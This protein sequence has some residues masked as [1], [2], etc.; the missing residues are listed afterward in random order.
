MELKSYQKDVIKN[1]RRYL[2]LMNAS[3]DYAKAYRDLMNEQGVIIG[4]G[5]VP[6]YKDTVA[7]TPHVCFKVPTG[8]G[9]TFLAVNSVRP[10][11]EAMP[12]SQ[13]KVVVWLV[14]SDA[15]LEQTYRNLSDK[16]SPYR[17]KLDVDFSGSVEVI[18]KQAALEGQCFNVTT[19]NES[20]I[21][22]VMSYDSFRA[23]N[24]EGRKVYQE[25]GALAQFAKIYK[26]KDITIADCDETALAQV[27]N[28]LNPLVVVDE[29]HH[30]TSNLSVDV[31]KNLNPCFILD[32]TATPKQNSNIIAYVD[33]LKLK[34]ESMV[35][36]P[37][38][39]YNRRTQ[40]DAI[41]DAVSLRNNLEAAAETERK[42]AGRYLRPIVL[43]Q[44]QPRTDTDSTTFE[45]IKDILINADIPAEQIA[46]KTS[47]I[48]ELKNVDL[49]S[50]DCPI[51]YIIT[52][53]ALKEGWDC[54]FAYILA[55]IANRS[56]IVD[57]EQILG[58]VLRQP[59]AKNFTSKFLNMSYVL[60][61]SDDFRATTENVIAG[62][63]SAGFSKRDMRL[64]KDA[65]AEVPAAHIQPVP[66]Q[67]LEINENKLL[68]NELDI[69]PNVLKAELA[70]IKES[71]SALVLTEE[72]QQAEAAA[73][74]YNA[75]VEEQSA[76]G[77]SSTSMELRD[78]MNLFY[79]NSEFADT[80]KNIKVPQ[81]FIKTD[82]VLFADDPY[83]LLD[84]ERLNDGFT[85]R[86]KS[87]EIDFSAT[88][89]EI[90]RID[91]EKSN[92]TPKSVNLSEWDTKAFKQYFN[93][94]TPAARTDACK[95][96]IEQQL[97]KIK[98]IDTEDLSMYVGRVVDLMNSDMLSDLEANV[99]RYA[100]K[101]KK[102]IEALLEEYAMKR[103]R[104]LIDKGKIVCR[105]SY[106]FEEPITPISSIETLS[107][108]LYTA[109]DKN[110]NGFE[111][112]AINKIASLDNVL[113]WH[114][115]TA[116]KG[117]CINGFTN[118]YPDFLVMTRSG[119]LVAVETKGDYLDTP[120][121]R[122]KLE[123]GRTWASKAGDD[124]AYYMVFQ[125]KKLNIDGAYHLDKFIDIIKEL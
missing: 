70:A 74:E 19:V 106:V 114:R 21:I 66:I 85:L 99:L 112:T 73:E 67:Q 119:R 15:I 71:P 97:D 40:N 60:T 36:L 30:A 110:M 53:N 81:F 14:P 42:T 122:Q 57:V 91:V 88:D 26:N 59:N 18:T 118:H 5:G 45:K 62:L 96:K 22:L 79:I 120:E 10:I 116:G 84:K 82:A 113:W 121:T 83:I 102:K 16:N 108:S 8:G 86:D 61:C 69:D 68:S 25:N 13:P 77:Y 4:A 27:L 37:V 95:R 2:E 109:E 43:F 28:C 1:L 100:D 98:C 87:T 75:A 29:S 105:P 39:V 41:R 3:G 104:G 55:T 93:S 89:G 90:V 6:D 38:I 80:V 124:F 7:H 64:G 101:I 123:L 50:E 33:A 35:K 103:F 17:R 12:L 125:H 56:S 65:S 49:M 44:A 92:T 31:L 47:N 24:K 76:S 117:F 48:N 23:K 115:V 107:K 32:L 11:F 54:P 9:K 58:R 78:K 52:V 20:L 46:I 51:R 94:L 63:N 34:K 111:Y 72:L